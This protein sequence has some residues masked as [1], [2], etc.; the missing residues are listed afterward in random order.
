MFCI[1]HKPENHIVC[2]SIPLRTREKL[3]KLIVL[4]IRKSSKILY[5]RSLFL[6]ILLW[7][8]FD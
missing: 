4:Y 1:L 7:T 3:S 6:Y 2:K 5:E 8:L